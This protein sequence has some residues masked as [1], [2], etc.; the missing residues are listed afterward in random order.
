M[1]SSLDVIKNSTIFVIEPSTGKV[2]A[3]HG[4]NEFYMPH[5]MTIDSKG[6]LWVT[7]VGRH[8]V[9]KLCGKT[10]KPVLILGEKLIPGDDEAHFCQP[11]DVAVS[12]DGQYVFIADGYCN[13]RIMQFDSNGTFIEQ[14]GNPPETMPAKNGEFFIPHSIALIEDLNLL[15]VADRENQ[16]IQCF[17][18]G[19]SQGHRQSSPTGM[20]ITKAE[21]IGRI[22]AIREK[23]HYL[24]GITGSS[25][26]SESIEP[27]VFVMDMDTGKAETYAKVRDLFTVTKIAF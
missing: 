21:N 26:D 7:D 13:A 22:Y 19:L 14:F 11:T 10:F 25:E 16:R 15:C 8:Q 12:A 24:V 18:A 17:S 5:G 1:S 23:R 20:F 3:E 4:E 27:Q 2:L 6:N 9:I